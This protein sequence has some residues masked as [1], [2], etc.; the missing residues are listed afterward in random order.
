MAYKRHY[1]ITIRCQFC[2][3]TLKDYPV[4]GP[5]LPK[6]CPRCSMNGAFTEHREKTIYIPDI[7]LR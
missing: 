1:R 2:G 3:L 7:K 5:E 6:R 4:R